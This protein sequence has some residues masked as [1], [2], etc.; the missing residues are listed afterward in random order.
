[1]SEFNAFRVGKRMFVVYGVRTTITFIDN[2][3]F[4]E[5]SFC[6]QNVDLLELSSFD[7]RIHFYSDIVFRNFHGC[8][9]V[10]HF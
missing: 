2:G 9:Y 1:M 8:L 3:L 6:A 4:S 5:M 10:L 7:L